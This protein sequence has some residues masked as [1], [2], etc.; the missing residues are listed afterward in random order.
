MSL[1]LC[2]SKDIRNLKKLKVAH[3][4][5]KCIYHGIEDEDDDVTSY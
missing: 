5:W 2:S 1:L 4:K 3:E